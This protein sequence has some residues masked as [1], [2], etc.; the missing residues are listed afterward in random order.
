MSLES[1]FNRFQALQ[2][3]IGKKALNALFPN[4]FEL[5]VFA[6]EL[7]NGQQETE[8][9]FIFPI[10]PSAIDEATAHNQ[11]IK[12]TAGGITVLNDSTFTPA[13]ITLNG[14]FGR[15]LKFLLG[16]E[17]ITFSGIT[18]QP[19]LGENAPTFNS[20][21]KT[22]YGCCKLVE[23]IINKS[24]SIDSKT[25]LPYALYFHNLAF[26][27][28]YLI[29][30]INYKFYQNQE[31]SNMIWNYNFQFKALARVED[32]TDRSQRSMTMALSANSVIQNR[33][34]QFGN[35]IKSFIKNTSVPDVIDNIESF[36]N[37]F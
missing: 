17:A 37:Y 12:K 15:Q 1:E 36:K 29:K 32:I 6:L 10:N 21:I 35:G 3:S 34:N 25:G 13:T 23:K 27:N 30:T 16:N 14:N 7:V 28:S 20:T 33:V 19:G 2:T 31:G 4:D 24:K 26:G 22:G 8:E 18:L 11:I 5:Y 9:Y